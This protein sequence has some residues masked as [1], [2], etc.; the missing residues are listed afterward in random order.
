MSVPGATVCTS[1]TADSRGALV[2]AF[3]TSIGRIVT[4]EGLMAWEGVSHLRYQA[5]A[6][7]QTCPQ[8]DQWFPQH[9]RRGRAFAEGG[10]VLGGRAIGA[11]IVCRSRRTGGQRELKPLLQAL[12]T[13]VSSENTRPS[14]A[15]PP[16][17]WLGPMLP[18]RKCSW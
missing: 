8:Q 14:L 16:P 17:G 13:H 9:P 18:P 12:G 11:G 15:G 5:E 1:V 7:A 10:H 2:W 4:T 6:F 3:L